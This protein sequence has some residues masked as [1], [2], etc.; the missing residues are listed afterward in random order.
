MKDQWPVAHYTDGVWNV[1][2]G[3][4]TEV[5]QLTLRRM[6]LGVSLR[7]VAELTGLGTVKTRQAHAEVRATFPYLVR[8]RKLIA[9]QYE[10]MEIA[11]GYRS[12]NNTV[13]DCTFESAAPER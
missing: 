10:C 8:A 2:P 7:E 4:M 11:R 13:T 9:Q 5:A 12:G 3:R 1:Y 6:L